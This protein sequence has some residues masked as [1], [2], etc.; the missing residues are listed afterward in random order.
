LR[1]FRLDG[2]GH[3]QTFCRSATW[4]F[5]HGSELVV[6][7]VGTDGMYSDEEVRTLAPTDPWN[8]LAGKLLKRGG[9]AVEMASGDDDRYLASLL[10]R[11]GRL[12][13]AQG[14]CRPVLR[15]KSESVDWYCL[16]HADDI[17]RE[18]PCTR[19]TVGLALH[20]GRAWVL[21]TWLTVAFGQIVE[22]TDLARFYYG[23]D[24][25][26]LR[27]RWERALSG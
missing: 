24:A 21:H 4:V 10:L 2:S 5:P 3:P 11:N 19:V 17:A 23:V 13:D 6:V 16:K 1:A 8:K 22:P 14:L 25:R 12:L 20:C 27:A 15:R 26:G 7:P 9:Q 18:L